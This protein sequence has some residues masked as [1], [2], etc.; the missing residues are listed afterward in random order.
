M[1]DD[2]TPSDSSNLSFE[3]AEFDGDAAA[4]AAGLGQLPPPLTCRVCSAP[5]V[6]EYFRANSQPLCPG[7]YQGVKDNHDAATGGVVYATGLGLA[8]A[9]VGTGLYYAV[10]AIVPGGIALVAIVVGVIVGKAVRRGAG[11]RG[12]WVYRVI[13]VGLTYLAIVST[14]VPQ[15][16]EGML[17]TGK[18]GGLADVLAA[19]MF[20][21]IVPG[22]MIAQME[23]MGLVILAIGLWEGYKFS[24]PP[25]LQ[26]SGP[27]SP[28]SEGAVLPSR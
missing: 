5:I 8:G 2:D 1:S 18:A 16:M 23:V 19:L 7:C 15:V 21:L 26:L 14:Y 27:F 13:A 11:V 24:A 20:S 9:V 6:T 12:H 22:F 3:R 17:A 4:P 10:A 28:P 25:V